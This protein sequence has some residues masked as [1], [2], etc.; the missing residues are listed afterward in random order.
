MLETRLLQHSRIHIVLK[1]SVIEWQTYTV[2]AQASKEFGIVLHEKVFEKLVEEEFLLFFS[3]D[4]QQSCSMLMLVAWV[5]CAFGRLVV[6]CLTE[7]VSLHEVFHVHPSSQ[8]CS[9]KDYSI[10]SAIN[11][12]LAIN[13]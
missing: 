8:A 1:V 5:S 9:A 6:C 3:Q 12:L 13:P 4:F 11:Y 10:S 7:T 2:Q